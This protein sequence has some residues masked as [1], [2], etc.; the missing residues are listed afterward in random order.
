MKLD[1]RNIERN[2]PGKGFEAVRDGH[3]IYFHHIYGGKRTGAYTFVSHSSRYRDI[4]SRGGIIDSMKKQLSLQ[5]AAQVRDLVN[6]PMN[7]EAYI[8]ALR[9][10]GKL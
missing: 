4:D 6:C 9:E 7:G 8:S 5:T 1:R 3:H 10:G 2:L